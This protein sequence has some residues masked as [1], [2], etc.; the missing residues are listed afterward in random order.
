MA[1]PQQVPLFFL[2][3]QTGSVMAKTTLAP[4]EVPVLSEKRAF[5]KSVTDDECVTC[6]C[7]C[8]HTPI[9]DMC[10]ERARAQE[11]VRVTGTR[12]RA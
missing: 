8:T 9:C 4:Q 1:K 12:Y 2:D 5:Q 11:H 7:L 10:A 3:Q 6:A